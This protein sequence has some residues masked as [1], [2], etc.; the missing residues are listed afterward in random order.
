LLLQALAKENMQS[1]W[2]RV[3]A[4][5]GAAG[6][7]G[8][9]IAQTQRHLA[10]AWPTIRDQLMAGTYRGSVSFFVCGAS[11][12][13]PLRHSPPNAQGT[14]VRRGGKVGSHSIRSFA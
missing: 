5:K 1:A 7:D 13:F 2:K 11:E 4:N 14:S 6:V 9:N 3:K 10:T 12:T 8:M